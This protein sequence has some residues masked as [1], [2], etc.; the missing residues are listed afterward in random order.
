MIRL[1]PFLQTG[2]AMN[3]R[4]ILLTGGML[5]S[6]VGTS[7]ADGLNSAGDNL[8]IGAH[9]SQFM[10]LVAGTAPTN[11]VILFGTG[12]PYTAWINTTAGT[13]SFSGM[14]IGG[15]IDVSGVATVGAI[16][17]AGSS[18]T[19]S[20]VNAANNLAAAPAC[21][22]TNNALTKNADGSFSCIA[23]SAGGGGTGS[24]GPAGPQGDKGDKGDTGPQGPAG[25]ALTVPAG[26]HFPGTI[27]CSLP[28]GTTRTQVPVSFEYR[29]ITRDG[30]VEYIGYFENNSFSATF[31]ITG[32]FIATQSAGTC[33]SQL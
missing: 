14:N 26:V 2:R 27:T 3:I 9:G 1:C 20:T 32:S 12:T 22:T 6:L 4:T 16:N 28:S 25:F 30:L 17:V 15:N 21:D 23:A 29:G 31:T 5:C 33:Q 13:A 18:I 11:N 24:Q 8:P 10:K 19:T 7:W